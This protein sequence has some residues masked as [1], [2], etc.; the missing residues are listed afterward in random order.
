MTISFI[1]V[2]YNEEKWLPG[3][4]DDLSKQDYPH[5][6]IEVVLVDSC[7]SDNTLD[8]MHSFR[9]EGHGFKEV[10]ILTNEKKTLPCGCNVALENCTGDA[11][12][13]VDGHAIIPQDFLSKNVEVLESGEDICG[14]KVE[15]ILDED[16]SLQQTLLIAENSIFCGGVASFRR[17]ETRE[18]VSTLAFAMYKKEVYDTVGGYNENLARTEDNEM[19][20]RIRNAGYKFCMDPAIKSSRFTRSSFGKLLKQKYGNGYW[21]GKTM[22]VCPKC[23][24]IYHFV[25]FVFLIG[26]IFTTGLAVLGHGFLAALMW[27]MY[28][29]AAVG[30]TVVESIKNKFYFYNLFLPFIFL[31]LHICY[32]YGT[33]MGLVE[34]PFWLRKISRNK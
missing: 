2:A 4:L 3:L 33:L 7:S 6:K 1:I 29:V 19:H 9:E 23:F 30:I 21:I 14:G 11:I 34:L 25:P 17:L 20:Y 27:S 24:S 18:Y 16:T 15:S 12:I 28:A 5:D 10:K 8:I 31:A 13:R 26:I 22:G 32:G